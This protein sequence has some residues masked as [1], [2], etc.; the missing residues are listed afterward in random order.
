MRILK[1]PPSIRPSGEDAHLITSAR[2]R[3]RTAGSRRPRGA[4]GETREGRVGRAA[5]CGRASVNAHAT[6][7]TADL[8][9]RRRRCERRRKSES[10]VP[11]IVS[12]PATPLR[13]ARVSFD[14]G[15]ADV[16]SRRPRAAP[17]TRAKGRLEPRGAARS[18]AATT[19]PRR[20]ARV[21]LALRRRHLRILRI[22]LL[23]LLLLSLDVRAANLRRRRPR[24]AA[25]RPRRARVVRPELPRGRRPRRGRGRVRKA[26]IETPR[27]P[28][29]RGGAA[30]RGGA[31]DVR[32]V[33]RL[34]VRARAVQTPTA[35]VVREPRAWGLP[36]GGASVPRRIQH[37]VAYGRAAVRPAAIRCVLYT[38]PHTTPSAW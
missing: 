38:G 30:L 35:D 22:L 21:L 7:T 36:G 34:R 14:D 2:S 19:T 32:G 10:H 4:S 31:G 27:R 33:R 15:G 17:R 5:C 20:R 3:V 26:A 25:R 24:R 13:D 1:T 28:L 9:Y 12:C 8:G 37:G 11:G 29:R 16:G 23:L 18:D 6:T